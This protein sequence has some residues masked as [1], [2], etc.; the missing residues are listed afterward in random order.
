MG[1]PARPQ[2]GQSGT[3]E[4]V[5]SRLR[6][7]VVHGYDTQK[8]Q[9]YLGSQLDSRPI[10]SGVQ[11]ALLKPCWLSG[12]CVSSG[13]EIEAAGKV[14]GRLQAPG[15]TLARRGKA[16]M[17]EDDDGWGAGLDWERVEQAALASRRL[18]DAPP[19]PDG[20]HAS[21]CLPGQG[22][23]APSASADGHCDRGAPGRPGEAQPC[24]RSTLA[25]SAAPPASL[26]GPERGPALGRATPPASCAGGARAAPGCAVNV[27]QLFA[28]SLGAQGFRGGVAVHSAPSAAQ[29]GL[30]A[31]AAPAAASTS[32]PGFGPG[33][34]ATSAAGGSDA[35]I[36]AHGHGAH[37]PQGAWPVGAPAWP[38]EAGTGAPVWPGEART[39]APGVARPAPDTLAP[40]TA[41]GVLGAGASGSA[42]AAPAQWRSA[43]LVQPDAWP[44][45]E[46]PAQG[47]APAGAGPGHM[48]GG[49]G[50]AAPGARAWPAT[51]HST[52]APAAV[53]CDA[54][55]ESC[56][57]GRAPPG[58]DAR[59]TADRLA[60]P[61]APAGAAGQWP[62]GAPNAAP[63]PPAWPAAAWPAHAPAQATDA[64]HGA[65][66]H[67]AAAQCDPAAAPADGAAPAGLLSGAA[68]GRG[69]A[70]GSG[71][72]DASACAAQ[73]AHARPA[74]APGGGDAGGAATA[75]PPCGGCP[76]AHVRV[77]LAL[78]PGGCLD[79]SCP[80]NE[81]LR[82]ALVR[83]ARRQAHIRPSPLPF[84]ND[85]RQRSAGCS[86]DWPLVA[87]AGV[88]VVRSSLVQKQK[89]GKALAMRVAHGPV[90]HTT[91]LRIMHHASCRPRRTCA[92]Q[93]TIREARAAERLVTCAPDPQAGRRAV[94]A[95]AA[96]VA[97]PAGAPARGGGGAARRAG[98]VCD[99]RGPAADRLRHPGGGPVVRGRVA[100]Y[101]GCS[102]RQA[103]A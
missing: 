98:R 50:H 4:M 27:R 51:D 62:G 67:V 18:S 8:V 102:A 17:W 42:P 92:A 74:A 73:P 29:R 93:S 16:G 10:R 79:V 60:A 14:A 15:R 87:R 35:G 43:E 3:G 55:H 63:D 78:A 49:G 30:D 94:D 11:E 47:F 52:T 44:L 95:G 77:Q 21:T 37:M 7:F 84:V 91:G 85:H 12:A 26:A 66:T 86:E 99:R 32:A 82:Q 70:P 45:A 56:G 69:G 46:R 68:A 80:Y 61:A 41:P 24:S 76:A 28:P 20:R 31:R 1:A 88:S 25:P 75:S 9:G 38:G 96:R 34:A 100:C 33:S 58:V 2:P 19:G 6:L 5:A 40:S 101:Q 36:R 48:L 65:G 22:M 23:P 72:F 97:L 64:G 90:R 103:R 13:A 59:P 39:R 89:F 57:T 83:R 81:R 54:S 53:G 71:V